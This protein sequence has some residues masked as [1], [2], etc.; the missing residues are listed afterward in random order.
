MPWYE[1]CPQE[2]VF[3]LDSS[4]KIAT[5]KDMQ[6]IQERVLEIKL[7]AI[8]SAERWVGQWGMATLVVLVGLASF[9]LGRLSALEDM[10]PMVSIGHAP[11]SSKP[12]AMALGAQFVASRTGTVYY[13]PWCGGA[14]QIPLEKQVWFAS[15]NA[16][17]KAGFRPA[18]N[19]KG[20]A[21]S[22]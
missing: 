11:I 21:N 22:Q 3:G 13:F 9:G 2:S 1:G 18:K 6:S 19:C 7:W 12:R 10:R 20:L 17:K 15:E 16:A 4:H 5:I 14:Q 8:K